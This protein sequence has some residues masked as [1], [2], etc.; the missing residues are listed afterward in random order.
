MLHFAEMRRRAT[1]MSLLSKM[2]R[3]FQTLY[4]PQ[5]I[6]LLHS[7]QTAPTSCCAER[8]LLLKCRALVLPMLSPC[9]FDA[10]FHAKHCC[11]GDNAP[12]RSPYTDAAL[13]LTELK[14]CCC[15]SAP[16]DRA[17]LKVAAGPQALLLNCCCLDGLLVLRS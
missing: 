4:M 15:Q 14:C 3:K 17:S 16:A 10:Q 5:R 1:V 2:L 13:A 7:C 11:C 6:L 8:L 9:W 12:L